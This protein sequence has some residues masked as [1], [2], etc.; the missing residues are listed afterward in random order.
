M[1]IADL[2]TVLCYGGALFAA[3]AY[4]YGY[5]IKSKGDRRWH[6]AGLLFTG[7]ALANLPPM[8]QATANGGQLFNAGAATVLLLLGLTCQSVTALRGRRGD[9]R[10]E[11]RERA[12]DAPA[13]AVAE[14]PK[15]V[16]PE[17]ARAA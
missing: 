10:G 11:R 9:R 6:T 13:L 17:A 3:A 5:V 2:L 4:V 12:S 14:A 8:I 7:L 1:T 16:A 15:P